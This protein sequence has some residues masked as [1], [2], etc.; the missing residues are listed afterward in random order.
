MTRLALGLAA[1]ACSAATPALAETAGRFSVST[2]VDYSSGDYGSAETTKILVAPVMASY[3][4]D[5]LRLS[6]TLPYLRI[7]GSGVVLGPDGQPLPGVPTASGTRSGIGDLSFGAT[8]SL[9]PESLGGFE[10][11]VG[12][13]VKLPTSKK[14]KGLGTGKTDFSVSAD[15]SYPVGRWAPFVTLGYRMPGDPTGV[16][17]D[18]SFTASIGSSLSLGR[19]VLIASYD[20]AESS[21]PLAKDSQELFAA[22]NAPVSR[23]VTWTGY[24]TAGLSDGAPDFGVGML[25]SYK[26]N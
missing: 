10:V 23:R 22:V 12:G 11:D 3:R 21:S 6:A 17:L 14:S 1:L 9:P 19:A 15:V 7:S 16:E 24:G 5:R 4:T 26:F 20:Y 2:G 18:N 8:A 25:V 13:R